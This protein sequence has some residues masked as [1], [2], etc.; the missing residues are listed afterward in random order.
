MFLVSSLH[1]PHFVVPQ[2]DIYRPTICRAQSL[3]AGL[4]ANGVWNELSLHTPILR[5]TDRKDD[6]SSASIAHLHCDNHKTTL[7]Q[8]QTQRTFLIS[9]HSPRCT[10][11]D[12]AVGVRSLPEARAFLTSVYVF[13]CNQ[14]FHNLKAV[15]NSGSTFAPY[16]ILPI[17]L[18]LKSVKHP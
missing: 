13:S 3:H 16:L 5:R 18:Q 14:N 12:N 15:L 8:M 4:L 17:V 11:T 1:V 6:W 7:T 10:V 9:S 2:A